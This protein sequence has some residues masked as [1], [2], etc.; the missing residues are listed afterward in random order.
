MPY[1]VLQSWCPISE[2][3]KVGKKFLEVS[4]KYPPDE[5]IAK[6]LVPTAV[7]TNEDGIVAITISEVK[8][9]KMF[10]ALD[11]AQ[12]SLIEYRTI[13]GYNYTIKF[14]FTAEEALESIGL[15]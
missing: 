8:K 2:S 11:R 13:R 14:W 15:G 1:L 10:E 7:T 12:K 3:D 5:S 4:E 9:E 6:D